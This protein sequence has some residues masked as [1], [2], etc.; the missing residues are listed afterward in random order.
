MLY[1]ISSPNSF[2]IC[3]LRTS[4]CLLRIL[5][6]S[7]WYI[8]INRIKSVSG[9]FYLI[10]LHI[11]SIKSTSFTFLIAIWFWIDICFRFIFYFSVT[12]GSIYYEIFPPK[13][14]GY[15]RVEWSDLLYWLSDLEELFETERRLCLPNWG[16][17]SNSRLFGFKIFWFPLNCWRSEKL[18]DFCIPV[19]SLIVDK[20]KFSTPFTFWNKPILS[21]NFLLLYW[22]TT[23]SYFYLFNL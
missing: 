22:N 21:K 13:V 5:A 9:Q 12:L 3:C 8:L 15:S 7:I 17:W 1:S 18:L 2:F 23:Y 10:M 11:S 19:F 16:T 4:C 6:S 20:F 14:G